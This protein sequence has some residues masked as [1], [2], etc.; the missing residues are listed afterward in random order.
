MG[1]RVVNYVYTVGM[2]CMLFLSPLDQSSL[3]LFRASV[4]YL[5]IHNLSRCHSEQLAEYGL[6]NLQAIHTYN[7]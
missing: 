6:W 1:E 7:K 3:A 2:Y 4:E 5:S